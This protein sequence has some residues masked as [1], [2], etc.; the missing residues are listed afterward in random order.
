[1]SKTY[2]TNHFLMLTV[3][4]KILAMYRREMSNV[5]PQRK[6]LQKMLEMCREV[7]TV[8]EIVEPGVSRLKGKSNRLK[9]IILVTK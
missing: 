9:Y 3:K 5:N 8:L 2:H 1:M 4:Q 6:V 7:L